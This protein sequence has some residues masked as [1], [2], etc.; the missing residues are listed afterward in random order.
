MQ[1]LFEVKAQ[2][3]ATWT[4]GFNIFRIYC[5]LKGHVQGTFDISKYGLKTRVTKESFN[6]RKDS[7]MFERIANKLDAKDAYK[8]IAYNLSSNPECI[9]F[10]LSGADSYLFYLKKTGILE[11]IHT[12]FADDIK[13]LFKTL[14]DNNKKFKDLFIGSDHPV[15]IQLL[16]R[17][18]INIESVILINSFIPVIEL[19]E[20]AYSDDIL[21]QKWYVKLVQYEKLCDINS[22][23]AKEIFTDTRA[24]IIY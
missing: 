17:E 16:I 23:L 5:A 18:E 1:T 19:M 21:W 20:K 9:S 11:R 2:T 3:P 15:I 8:L 6:K 4:N 14:H 24:S 22:K 13:V 10:E 7:V 12:V